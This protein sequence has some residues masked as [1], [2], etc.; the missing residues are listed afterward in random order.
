MWVWEAAVMVISGAGD[1]GAPEWG[2]F[3]K[4]VSVAL[5]EGLTTA[6]QRV[7]TS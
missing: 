1:A 7:G 3:I 6:G 2:K 4:A 5:A